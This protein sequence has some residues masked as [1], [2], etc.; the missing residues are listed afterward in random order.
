MVL[1]SANMFAQNKKDINTI[2][3]EEVLELSIEELANYDLEEVMQLMDIVG[4]STME[5]LYELLLNKAVTSASKSEEN[6]FDSPLSTT[7]LSYEEILG[8]GATSI[9]EALRLVP[10]VIVREKTNGSYD[11]QIRGGQNMPMNN[12]LIYAENTTTLVMVDGRPA[13]NY[14]M[15]GI[16]WESLP[17]SLGEL[18]RIE[19][20]RGPSSALYGPNAV[21]GV[22]NLISKR[23]TED[24]PIVTANAQGGSLGTYIGDVNVKKRFNEKIGVGVSAYFE[25]R[26][27]NTDEIYSLYSDEFIS[28]EEYG[29]K[30]DMYKWSNDD[31]SQLFE[32]PSRAK[33]KLGVNAYLD[34]LLSEDLSFNINAGYLDAMA[35]TST[36]GD[37]PTPYNVR[38]GYSHYATLNSNIYGFNFIGSL[39]KNTQDYCL[40]RTGWTQGFEIYNLSLDYLLDFDKLT[41]RPGISYQSVYQDDREHIEELGQG[42]FNERVNLTNYSVSARFDYTPTEKIRLVAALRG[43]KYSTPDKWAPSYQFIASY[44][45]NDNNLLRAVYSRAN[46]STFMINAHSNYT[47][48]REGLGSPEYVY[49]GGNDDPSLMTMDMIELGYRTRPSKK[50]LLDFELFYNKANNYSALMPDMMETH[51]SDTPADPTSYNPIT[52][53]S[54]SHRALDVNSKQYGLSFSADVVFSEK[55]IMKAHATYQQTSVDDFMDA[56]RDDVAAYQASQYQGQMQNDVEQYVMYIMSGGAA[57]SPTPPQSTYSSDAQ[58]DKS[59][60]K[61]G[62]EN[63]AV[64]SFWG[65][66]ALTYKPIKKLAITAQGYYY[67][68]Y[69]LYTQYDT[70]AKRLYL[71]GQ[72]PK[73]LAY[74][75]S[76][77][78]EQKSNLEYTGNIN[79]KFLLN[80]KI[81]YEVN[82]NLNVFVNGRNILNN[83]TQEYAFMDT[84][85]ALYLAGVNIKF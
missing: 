39:S 29:I 81:N 49:F 40:G 28:Q 59:T 48:N 73:E 52:T 77:A 27:R 46:Q 34:L 25:Q 35:T 3:K 7:V 36:L 53:L 5:E 62:V 56:S 58:L 31:A 67:D 69:N 60:Y 54:T 47:W 16:L 42:Y 51:L 9:E 63:E 12:M 65:S 20:V 75:V 43:E 44:K 13:F 70:S 8:S 18:D 26:D 1:V 66:L 14:G 4:A 10:G 22:I 57:G 84:I 11:V 85:G 64:P 6:L 83:E 32:D 30:N 78:P 15:G 21:N 55:L 82:R 17:I 79:S 33:E 2:T 68:Q 45:V 61:N 50:V 24:S 41:I 72:V 80:A 37:N 76:D 38:D 74:P 71:I 19:V 23:V